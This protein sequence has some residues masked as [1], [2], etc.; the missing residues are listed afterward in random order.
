MNSPSCKTTERPIMSRN[1]YEGL[2]TMMNQV[3]KMLF[4]RNFVENGEQSDIIKN[5][6]GR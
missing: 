4:K 2:M 1:I 6:K 5:K 3:F